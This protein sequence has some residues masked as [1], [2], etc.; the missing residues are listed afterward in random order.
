MDKEM[1]LQPP[2]SYIARPVRMED[3]QSA[4]DL[5]NAYSQAL[6]GI[7]QESVDNTLDWWKGKQFN[8]ETDSQ[9]VLTPEGQAAG[10]IEFIDLAEPHVHLASWA[11]VHPDHKRRGIGTYLL[12]WLEE[13][14]RQ[15]LGRSPAE[16]RV[17][18]WQSQYE[19]DRDCH[20]LFMAA[21]FT[22]V[23][24]YWNM[25]IDMEAVPAVPAPPEAIIIRG[26][27]VS[28]EEKEV[29]RTIQDSFKDHWG[30]VAEPF[31]RFYARF[32]DLAGRGEN[33]DPSLWFV[34]MDGDEMAGVCIC[35]PHVPEDVTMGYVN[36]LGVRRSWRKKGLGLAL[37]RHAFSQ[38]YR[39]GMEKVS[40]MVDS[41][42][43]TG[44]VKL[45]ERAGMRV[46][47]SSILYEKELRP[48]KELGTNTL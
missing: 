17:S 35:K 8:N 33:F 22:P 40:L 16:T 6:Y 31:E 4:V 24:S 15:N 7:N 10:Y 2:Q 45:Y 32:M 3:V 42:S 23:R 46:V 48:G 44:A 39:R 14:A 29:V 30:V 19:A 25:R 1:K 12:A 20:P 38:F 9:L 18:L 28:Q 13:R 47:R 21:G 36:T 11:C 26:M 41:D 5:Y 27:R 43:L 34:A 37:L